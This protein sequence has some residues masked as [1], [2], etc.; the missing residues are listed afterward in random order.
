VSSVEPEHDEPDA[1]ARELLAATAALT[2][3]LAGGI[4]ALRRKG[5]EDELVGM[6]VAGVFDH[7]PGQGPR[8]RAGR[9]SPQV[10]A[11]AEAAAAEARARLGWAAGEH[12]PALVPLALAA[13]YV[14][15]GRRTGA[16]G[17]GDV[18]EPTAGLL[19]GEAAHRDPTLPVGGRLLRVW[20]V[21][22]ATGDACVEL[23]FPVA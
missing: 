11:L 1:L 17:L 18:G 10:L 19:V 12:N 8:H 13:F 23:R 5:A 2:A 4:D 20:A 21:T 3:E 22:R 7:R 6:P 14:V 16:L 9:P 15:E